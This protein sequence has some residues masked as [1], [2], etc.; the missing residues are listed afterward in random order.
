MVSGHVL[1]DSFVVP[2]PGLTIRCSSCH[3][4]H[5]DALTRPKPPP[6][7]I[8]AAQ[9]TGNNY[10]WCEGCHDD[11]SSWAAAGYPYPTGS[12]EATQ[13]LRAPNGYPSLGT[14]PGA[15]VFND[16]QTNA[17]NPVT[18]TNVV[19]PGSGLLSGDCRNCHASHGGAGQYDALRAEFRPTPDATSTASDRA[20]GTYAALC[21]TCHDSDG[22][23]SRDIKQFTSMDASATGDLYTGGHR[24]AT[25]GGTLPEG[26]PLPCYDCHNPHGSKGNDG[27]NPNSSLV[28]DEQWSGID[29]STTAGVVGFCMKRHLPWE[30]A[31]GSGQPDAGTIPAGQL[32]RIEG[33]DRRDPSNKLSLIEGIVAHGA[34]EHGHA[35]AQLL[36]LPHER[37]L[38]RLRG[39]DGRR[40]FQRAS[41]RPRPG[42]MR[43]LSQSASGHA[44]GGRGRVRGHQPSRGG[45]RRDRRRLW[46]VSH[47]T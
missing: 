25:A 5:V 27:T 8:G 16:T 37:A 47:G 9:V 38:G 23:S 3:D 1:E 21:F 10:T 22:P 46:R 6:L 42:R 33:L 29:T 44:A 35:D 43:R 28:S 26:A 15:T 30:H 11:A 2:G 20:D 18:S 34:G 19:W 17:H 31:Q 32:E 36:R 40:R 39:S 12:I 24:I 13:P 4:P 45:G 14:F 41:A 7:A